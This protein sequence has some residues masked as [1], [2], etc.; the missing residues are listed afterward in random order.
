MDGILHYTVTNMPGAV[1][2]T[3]TAALVNHTVKYGL[4]VSDEGIEKASSISPAIAKGMN[5]HRGHCVH[6]RVAKAL[7]LN[8]R[9]LEE[10]INKG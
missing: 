4:L 7:G 10:L 8:C 2:V 5:T 9:P 1:P 6:A 3:A